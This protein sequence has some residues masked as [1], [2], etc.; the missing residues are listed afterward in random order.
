MKNLNIKTIGVLAISLLMT[1]ACSNTKNVSSTS[2]TATEST[3]RTVEAEVVKTNTRIQNS[4]NVSLKKAESDAPKINLQPMN[5]NSRE[6][7]QKKELPAV[8]K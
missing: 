5:S 1:T 7:M 4:R 6:V 3:E 8:V 2:N